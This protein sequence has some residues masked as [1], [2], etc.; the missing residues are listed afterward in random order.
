ME[1]M[2]QQVAEDARKEGDAALQAAVSRQQELNAA[3]DEL[4]HAQDRITELTA[5]EA[6][7]RRRTEAAQ[8]QVCLPHRL[9]CS[10]IICLAAQF[11][12]VA[13]VVP[14]SGS[15][16]VMSSSPD[17]HAFASHR[18]GPSKL[19]QATYVHNICCASCVLRE[20]LLLIVS[21]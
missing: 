1:R 2:W 8:Q 13:Q 6:N 10:S 5:L 7:W 11:C 21:C 17:T 9:S 19:A 16:G 14:C 12:A 18:F 15:V 4:R 20:L 3:R